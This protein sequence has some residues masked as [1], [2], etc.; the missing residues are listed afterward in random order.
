MTDAGVLVKLDG[1]LGNQMFQYALGRALSLRYNVPLALDADV[2]HSYTTRQYALGVFNV[3]VTG[4]V[5]PGTPTATPPLVHSAGRALGQLARKILPTS[6]TS[7]RR[8]VAGGRLATV[9]DWAPPGPWTTLREREHFTFDEAVLAS[10][11]PVFLVGYWQNERYFADYADAVRRDFTLR[12]GL[13]EKAKR[14]QQQITERQP[15]VSLHVR[16]GDYVRTKEARERLDVC[17]VDYYRRA[18]DFLNSKIP[19]ASIFVFSD[20]ITWVRDNLKIDNAVYVDGCA[21]FEELFLMSCCRH[22]IIANSSFSWWGAWLNAH[23]EKIV[24]A[25]RQWVNA[26]ISGRTPVPAGWNRL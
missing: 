11:P 18:L 21:D 5:A 8:R 26:D 4:T 6:F 2:Y 13:S 7:L 9:P 17:G 23:A 22:N 19:G 10:R 3:S 14:F 25:P 20:E 15:S 1:G 24:V 12:V 16:R